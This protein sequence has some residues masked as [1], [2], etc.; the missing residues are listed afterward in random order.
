V[1]TFVKFTCWHYSYRADSD[2]FAIRGIT[3]RSDEAFTTSGGGGFDPTAI[4]AMTYHWLIA[5][6]I[7]FIFKLVVFL[8][9]LCALSLPDG[10]VG[11]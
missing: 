5:D 4:K 2:F 8:C 1:S 6:R 3:L 11:E 7:R 10:A 9:L